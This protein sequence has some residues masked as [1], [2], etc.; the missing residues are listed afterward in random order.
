MYIAQGDRW[1]SGEDTIQ[2]TLQPR[3]TAPLLDHLANTR[4][5]GCL[6][7]SSGEV[8]WRL[9]WEDGK[10]TY[11][12]QSVEPFDR[13][14]RHLR[15]LG[16]QPPT[17]NNS[18]RPPFLEDNDNPTHQA[19]GWLV[20]Q[21]YLEPE[22]AA[23]ILEQREQAIAAVQDLDYQAL[24]WLLDQQVLS[25]FQAAALAEELAKEV[26]ESLLWI[27]TGTYAFHAH[28]SAIP[29][30]CRLDIQPLVEHGHQRLQAWQQLGPKI[31]SPYQRPYLFNQAGFSQSSAA[32]ELNPAAKE[33]L[34][35]IL[36][37]FSFRHLAVLLKQDE[38]KLA[39]GLQAYIANGT[40]YLREPRPPFDG[41][42][43]IP[44]T[45]LG[46]AALETAVSP[47]APGPEPGSQ[48]TYTIACVDDSPTILS[49]ISRFLDD[50]SFTVHPINDP[51]KALMQITRIKPDL[52]LLDVGMPNIDG[53]ELCRLLRNHPLF[54]STPIVMV[55]GHT[56]IIDRAR[57]KFVGASD[58]LTKPFT[59]SSLL[60]VAFKHLS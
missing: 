53:Y 37:G 28:T 36:K 7:V 21:R 23:A 3:S 12:A 2:G 51:V 22:Q 19:I 34:A 33:K 35:A 8:C 1:T 11:A 4:H 52:I 54:K 10:L 43:R 15:R 39:Q 55:T 57:A 46:A 44:A 29:Q 32:S 26:I 17:S 18:S 60:K 48:K 58:Y 45:I 42:P 6:V 16:Y 25:S 20:R 24:Y 27:E 56:G 41:L 40:V 14:D 30:I 5:S 49:E 59:Q 13:L 50:Q 47:P 38:L 9:Y 31:W